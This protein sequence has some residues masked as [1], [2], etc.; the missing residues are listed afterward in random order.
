MKECWV[1][2]YESGSAIT[3]RRFL[4]NIC[5]P[6]FGIC[7]YRLHIKLKDKPDA[8]KYRYPFKFIG[9]NSTVIDLN[10]QI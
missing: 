9:N 3:T 10:D 7:L 8:M 6:T 2:V 4:Y 1:N 5:N